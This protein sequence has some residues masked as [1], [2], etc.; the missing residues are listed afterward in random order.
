MRTCVLSASGN[1]FLCQKGEGT[2][3]Q[4]TFLVLDKRAQGLI[5][6]DA[7]TME[8]VMRCRARQRGEA[9]PK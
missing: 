7:Q 8:Q 3:E 9:A 6:F 1:A 2:V 5:C 4:E